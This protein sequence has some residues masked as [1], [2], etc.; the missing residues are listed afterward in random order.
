MPFK[1]FKL[2]FGC[3][4]RFYICFLIFLLA[5][6]IFF[7]SFS[8]LHSP[9]TGLI[10]KV[11]KIVFFATDYNKQI[12]KPLYIRS[13]FGLLKF[14]SWN[15]VFLCK[16]VLWYTVNIYFV[17]N[18]MDLLCFSLSH[19]LAVISTTYL[20]ILWIVVFWPNC[21]KFVVKVTTICRTQDKESN[22]RHPW[23]DYWSQKEI[24]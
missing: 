14:I 17:K 9:L 12:I 22:S 19:V 20:S 11:S 6:V 8:P 15:S 5:I 13:S 21:N 10:S 18:A 2:D 4:L 3:L 16:W 7:H 1:R 23:T 24:S